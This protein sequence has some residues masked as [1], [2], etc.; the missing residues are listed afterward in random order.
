MLARV[1]ENL[2]WMGRYIER[3]ECNM[4]YIREEFFSTLEAPMTP[5]RDYV[6]RSILF[7]GTN[8]AD[9]YED[10]KD[11]A[12]WKNAIFDMANP[13]SIISNINQVRENA[14]GIRNTISAELW[15]SIN[16]WYI[17]CKDREAE[18]FTLKEIND[19]SEDMT[20]HLAMIKYSM[21]NTQ[22]HNLGWHFMNVG[23]MMERTLS[24]SRILR[25]KIVDYN[26]LSNQGKNKSMLI[27]QWTIL[28]KSVGAYDVHQTVSRKKLMSQETI[29]PL[30]LANELFP[31]SIL[32]S[33]KKCSTHL[34]RLSQYIYIAP[35]NFKMLK[36]LSQQLKEIDQ[37]NGEQLV[38]HTLEQ[39]QEI[40]S[41]CHNAIHSEFFE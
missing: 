30:L 29:F 26:I 17:Y 18:T 9:T 37:Q 10:I 27:Y 35:N 23:L 31:R 16:R 19:F 8:N 11:S 33:V 20:T 22:L 5:H 28:L 6:I 15:E 13:N 21:V 39:I 36:D 14:R 32:Y 25:G 34:S 2:Y 4:R 38:I 1:A 40:M 7:L 41:D 3:A 24:L 12:V